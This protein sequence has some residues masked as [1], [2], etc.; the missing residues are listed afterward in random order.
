MDRAPPSDVAENPVILDAVL[1]P[2][3]SLSRR[4]FVILMTAVALVGFAGG[5]AF[6]Y[7]G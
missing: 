4:G 7:L 6:V 3:R 5:V 1:H 2:Y